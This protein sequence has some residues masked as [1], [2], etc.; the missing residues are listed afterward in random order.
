MKIG[1]WGAVGRMV[2]VALVSAVIFA[3]PAM[4][5]PSRQAGARIG[6]GIFEG[7]CQNYD[8]APAFELTAPEKPQGEAVRGLPAVSETRIRVRLAALQ[9]NPLVIVV[10]RGRPEAAVACGVIHTVTSPDGTL[11]TTGLLEQNR[12][13]YIGVGVI[14]AEEDGTNVRLY[15]ARGLTGGY[16][17][18][19]SDDDGQDVSDV[20]DTVTV[21]V[22]DE[23]LIADQTEFSVGDT[24]L[25][26]VL[27]E[28]E[29]RHEVILEERDATEAPLDIDDE[30]QAET[31][32]IAPE[33]DASFI[34]TFED[35]GEFQIADH[36]GDHYEEGMVV[37]IVVT[38]S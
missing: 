17:A 10:F 7:S 30:T 15:V 4:A 13:L 24:V 16:G 19:G 38:D 6:A 29:Q 20:T 5:Q 1:R 26:E 32:D 25:F 18:T 33:G 11:L 12:S 35:E 8:A 36:I 3:G 27:N 2:G 37:E 31:E 34:Y 14:Q 23:E 22:N 9:A 21:T 28:G